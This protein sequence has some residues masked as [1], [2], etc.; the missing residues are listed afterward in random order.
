MSGSIPGRGGGDDG[1]QAGDVVVL[2]EIGFG[3]LGDEARETAERE[4]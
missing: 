1:A 3:F 4:K 2:G